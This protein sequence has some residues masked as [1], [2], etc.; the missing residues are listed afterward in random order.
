MRS[1]RIVITTFS[2]TLSEVASKR[3][4]ACMYT[5]LGAGLGAVCAT[6]VR[7]ASANRMGARNRFIGET[8]L[9]LF[10]DDWL[11]FDCYLS[12]DIKIN[13]NAR[14]YA[15][16]MLLRKKSQH[17]STSIRSNGET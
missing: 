11:S 17:D 5:G 14:V 3:C 13:A 16:C 10:L 12:Q 9:F 8:P 4:P 7:L 15:E 6:R 2:R 1:P